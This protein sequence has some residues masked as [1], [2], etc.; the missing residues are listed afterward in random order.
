[1]KN[2][3]KK[4]LAFFLCLSMLPMMGCA[5]ASK[6]PISKTATLFDTVISISIYDKGSE[7]L[8][9]TCIEMCENYEKKFSRTLEGSEI[10]QLNHANGQ[11]VELSNETIE[12]LNK[13][14]YYC[15]LSEG[16]FDIT[17]APLSDLWNFQNNPGVLPTPE[18]IQEAKSH[19]DYKNISID[20]NKVQLLDPYAAVDLGGIAKGYV[21]D[22]LKAYLKSQDVSYA[23]IN[24]GGNVL[25][26]GE[27]PDGSY[28]NIGIQKPFSETGE[29]ITSVKIKDQSV[30][31]SGIYQRYFKIED[32]IYHHILNPETGYPY[33][34]ELSGVTI[35]CDHSTDADALS[36]L[37]F[38]LGRKAGLKLIDSLN[39]TEAIFITK[40]NQIYYSKGLKK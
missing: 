21:A 1:M 29:A 5:N 39:D 23:L 16:R 10:Y 37:C 27:K 31:S 36:T 40:E 34:G 24:L 3:F 19:V 11:P 38:I 17:I 20:G 7:H 35:V 6:T 14:L 33:E 15:Q 13:A 9:D 4:C 12:V 32:T 2:P 30:V 25:A 26:L 18:E 8:L 22:Q 28:Y